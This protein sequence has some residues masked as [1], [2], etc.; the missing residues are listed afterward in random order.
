MTEGHKPRGRRDYLPDRRILTASDQAERT[1]LFVAFGENVRR[2]REQ[3]G[4]TQ[5]QLGIG[6]DLPHTFISQLENGVRPPNL[7]MLMMLAHA[8]NVQPAELLMGLS[9]PVRQHTARALIAEVRKQP[10]IATG[11][12]AQTLRVGPGYVTMLGDRLVQEG[13]IARENR[14]YRPLSGYG[15]AGIAGAEGT[16]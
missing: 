13:R 3:A 1:N 2:K 15:E 11:A 5:K 16:R 8:L 6:S 4:M 7:V 14:R 10:R 12:L 9:A